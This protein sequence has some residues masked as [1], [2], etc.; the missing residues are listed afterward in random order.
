MIT[1]NAKD[2][3]PQIDILRG[4]FEHRATWAYLLIEEARKKGLD[5]DFA[6]KAIFNCGCFHANNKLTKTDDLVKFEAEF[7]PPHIKDI[8]QM[9]VKVDSKEL[10]VKFGYCPL[11]AAW[12]KL[13]ASEEEIAELCEIAMDGDRGIADVFDFEFELGETIA[14]GN[15]GCQLWFRKK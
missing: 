9:D 11:V 6:H 14:K 7:L 12:Q 10:Y 8:F 1:N 5:Y 3:G 13:G 2:K 15:D 4:A